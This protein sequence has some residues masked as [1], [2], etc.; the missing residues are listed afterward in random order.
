M[1]FGEVRVDFVT[2]EISRSEKPIAL[3]PQAFKLLRF[4]TQSPERVISRDELLNEVW[5]YNNY[6]STR[7]VDN[8]IF[9]LRRKLE[10][11]PACPVHFLTVNRMGYRFVPWAAERCPAADLRL[12]ME[13]AV[14]QGLAQYATRHTPDEDLA[15][16]EASTSGDIAAFEELV[17]RYDRKLLRI[18]QRVTDNLEDAQEVVQETFLKAFQKL[19]QFQRNSKFS[20][21]LIRIA[22]NESLMTLRRRRRYTQELPLEYEDP[23]GKNLPLDV[24]DW[25]P[26]PEQL[27]SRSELQEILRKALEELPL[28]LRVVFV[29]RDV[30]VLSIKETAAALD[31]H[32]S[33]V[34]ARLLRARLQL[35]E[36]LS[37]FFRPCHR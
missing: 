26:N 13:V 1:R 28:A 7:T 3:T 22:L 36:K 29:L 23:N 8:H 31:L 15:L 27:Y 30:E 4:F 2:M 18:A 16:V 14:K 11:N 24:A 32:P 17:R 9:M 19:K 10:L 25:S 12:L 6:P 5:G 20:T 34:K 21:W 35:R 37:N 33:A